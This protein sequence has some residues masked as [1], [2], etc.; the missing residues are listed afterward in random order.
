MIE[1]STLQS[2][3]HLKG[4]NIV[5]WTY[6]IFMGSSVAL[7]IYPFQSFLGFSQLDALEIIPDVPL[8]SL[9]LS[10]F[11][12]TF[13]LSSYPFDRPNRSEVF[14]VTIMSL[15]FALLTIKM[16]PL[17][18][19]HSY[20]I[21]LTDTSF[22]SQY[23]HF[24]IPLPTLNV[25]YLEYPAI[26]LLTLFAITMTGIKGY[27]AMNIIHSVLYEVVGLAIYGLTQRLVKNS[28]L[29]ATA[30]ALFFSFSLESAMGYTLFFPHTL[31]VT[32][33]AL[34]L[35]TLLIW[36][37]TLQRYLLGLIIASGMVVSHFHDL[38]D[39]IF[40]SMVVI[41][42]IAGIRKSSFR[43]F[44]FWIISV[45]VSYFFYFAVDTSSSLITSVHMSFTSLM[46][47]Q[48]WTNYIG[49]VATANTFGVPFWAT[50]IRYYDIFLTS[51]A[52]TIVAV[53]YVIRHIFRKHGNDLTLATIYSAAALGVMI[54]GLLAFLASAG[55]AGG[56]LGPGGGFN[57][58]VGPE[59]VVFVSV[60]LFL[61]FISKHK[62]AIVLLIV[63]TSTLSAPSI[64][65][66]TYHQIGTIAIN[67]Y[68]LNVGNFVLKYGDIGV[69]IQ[70]DFKTGGVI[71]SLDPTIELNYYQIP[72][73]E[74]YYNPGAI[75][76]VDVSYS[77][78]QLHLYNYSIGT[79]QLS[80]KDLVFDNG[81]CYLLPPSFA[82]SQ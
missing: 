71:T 30:V 3:N 7:L 33:F 31:G 14:K 56:A 29:S 68:E 41:V 20:A 6:Y 69:P 10:I 19:D 45:W 51:F 46:N 2:K 1:D 54:F 36:P 21:T 59:Y 5:K 15:I 13:I 74:Y 67:G 77:N 22:L 25:V 50:F 32:L 78:Y 35:L 82:S 65:S 62:K 80:K 63:L 79:Q 57:L 11:V 72:I 9:V 52:G 73:Q 53:V 48:I 60:P 81:L 4:R 28:M 8:F 47:G 64:F 18:V 49:Q 23:S 34:V 75:N 17:G 26:S 40:I 76:V 55:P 24:S 16:A 44:V 42:L 27:L 70:T 39:L 61:L 58:L 66:L 38:L 37:I 43:F 12:L